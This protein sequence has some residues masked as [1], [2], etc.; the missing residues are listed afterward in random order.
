V[1]RG[2]GESSEGNFNWQNE[3]DVV[4]S[5]RNWGFEITPVESTCK[6]RITENGGIY[7]PIFRFVARFIFGDASTRETCLE[8][9]CS[10]LSENVQ[11]EN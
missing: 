5:A 7:K 1:S 9:L 10:N 11:A 2:R 3:I 6:L 8:A 4:G